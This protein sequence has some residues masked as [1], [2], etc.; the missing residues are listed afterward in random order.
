MSFYR[1]KLTL[2]EF[3]PYIDGNGHRREHT[4]SVAEVVV[5]GSTASEAVDQMRN[6][7]GELQTW[8]AATPPVSHSDTDKE[9]S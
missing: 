7:V 5:T 6:H 1:A 2:E 9:K 4:N 3:E 8:H